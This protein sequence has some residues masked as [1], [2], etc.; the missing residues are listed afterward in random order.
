MGP[1][2]AV[3]GDDWISFYFVKLFKSGKNKKKIIICCVAE[4]SLFLDVIF[5][6]AKP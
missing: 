6:F 4:V 2:S 1:V 3:R 5:S